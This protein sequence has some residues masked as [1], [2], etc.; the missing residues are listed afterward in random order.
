MD[1]IQLLYYIT[2]M[3]AA[4]RFNDLHIFSNFRLIMIFIIITLLF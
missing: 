3:H 1:T 2:L 4:A